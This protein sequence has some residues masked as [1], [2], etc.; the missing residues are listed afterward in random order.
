MDQPERAGLVVLHI[1]CF[2]L[3]DQVDQGRMAVE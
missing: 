2:V 3:A 1:C